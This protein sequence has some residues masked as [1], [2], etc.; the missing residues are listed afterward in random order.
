M[1]NSNGN[2]SSNNGRRAPS[3]GKCHPAENQT[4]RIP[5]TTNVT[6]EVSGS[7]FCIVPHLFQHIESLPWKKNKLPSIGTK[8]TLKLNANPDLFE[9][10]LQFFLYGNLPDPKTLSTH[11]AKRLINFVSPLDPVAVKPLVEYLQSI[12]NERS[13]STTGKRSLLTKQSLSNFS[14]SLASRSSW[15][16]IVNPDKTQRME[17]GTFENK[18]AKMAP[19]K[20]I[21]SQPIIPSHVEH[22]VP[23]SMTA[24]EISVSSMDES[25]SISKLSVQSSS[26]SLVT[27]PGRTQDENLISLSA[28]ALFPH[29]NHRHPVQIQNHRHEEQHHPWF[30][31]QQQ[32][33][34]QQQ[35]FNANHNAQM[36]ANLFVPSIDIYSAIPVSKSMSS[37]SDQRYPSCHHCYEHDGAQRGTMYNNPF[38]RIENVMTTSVRRTAS[39]NCNRTNGKTSSEINGSSSHKRRSVTKLIRNVLSGSDVAAAVAKSSVGDGV[40]AS[41]NKIGFNVNNFFGRKPQLQMTHAEWCASE[42]VV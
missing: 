40:D 25:S 36:I 2:G 29:P 35:H 34:Q 26:E 6:V 42:H 39:H 7:Q 33:Q 28:S 32:Q 15:K 9:C 18:N 21:P 30:Q 11:R 20:Q 4:K 23:S 41:S 31:Q 14:T 38:T 8:A 27:P 16:K 10:V 1:A 17:T 37:E 13:A 5:R 24:T 3:G 22:P 19:S 12:L